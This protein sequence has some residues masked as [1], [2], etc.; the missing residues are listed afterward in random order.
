MLHQSQ[1]SMYCIHTGIPTGLPGLSTSGISVSF[2]EGEG[3]GI[4]LTVSGCEIH[5][6]IVCHL[7]II[8]SMNE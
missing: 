2:F 1:K 6:H 8:A 3:D 5:R 4:S 7:S